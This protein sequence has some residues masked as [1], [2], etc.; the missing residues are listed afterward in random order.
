M[1]D[2]AG[3]ARA[4]AFSVGG[5][6]LYLARTLIQLGYEPQGPDK[7]GKLPNLFSYLS[8]IK[9]RR[10]YMS[11][12]TGFRFYLPCVVIKKASYDFMAS[13]TNHKK[14][15]RN[16]DISE[17]V[18]VCLKE[19]MIR[20]HT[21]V[22]TYPLVTLG[23]SYISSSFFGNHEPI[24]YTVA[25]LYKGLAPKLIVEVIMVWVTIMSRRVTVEFIL[26]DFFQTI[27]ARVPPFIAQAFLYPFNV[28]S[29]VMAD[30]GRS[31]LNPRFDDWSS[32]YRYL[33][34]ANQLK[35]GASIFQRRYYP[36]VGTSTLS[37]LD[38]LP[39]IMPA[40]E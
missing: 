26:D 11:L 2:Q 3:F 12:Y 31:G 40:I 32:C 16:S 29:T 17:V 38:N 36:L 35:R 34:S 8:I 13:M 4:V 21:T 1:D 25:T 39:R 24:D 14:E 15:A 18:A 20:I 33:G 27:I 19:S 7:Y 28:V 30:N 9:D 10:G 23:V 6:P 22:L 37:R 5:Y